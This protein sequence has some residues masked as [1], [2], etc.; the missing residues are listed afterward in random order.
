MFLPL[1]SPEMNLIEGLW[2][3]VINNVFYHSLPQV[4]N[5]VEK[6]IRNINMVPTQTIERL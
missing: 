6:F 2:G 4:R 1:Y 5:A 3:S